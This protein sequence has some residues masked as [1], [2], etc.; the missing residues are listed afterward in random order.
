MVLVTREEADMIR[1]RVPAAHIA[2][3]NRGKGNR[4]RYYV[5]ESRDVKSLLH[6]MRSDPKGNTRK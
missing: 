1:V 2:I 6:E 3:T 4:K 5:E